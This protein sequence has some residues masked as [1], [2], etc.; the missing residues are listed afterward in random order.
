[1]QGF[2]VVLDIK[3]RAAEEFV[4]TTAISANLGRLVHRGTQV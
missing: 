3:I 1:M 2:A 4:Q